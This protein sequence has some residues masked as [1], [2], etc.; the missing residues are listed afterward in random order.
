VTD[1]RAIPDAVQWHEGM[2]LSPQHFQQA[3]LRA[4]GLLSYLAFA[5]APYAWGVRRLQIDQAALVGG[6]FFV[7]DLEAVMP[8]GLLVLHP[9]DPRLPALELDLLALPPEAAA[10]GRLAVHLT[11][12][13]QSVLASRTGELQRYTALEGPEA[14]DANT[15]DNAIAIPRLLPVLGLQCTDGPQRPPSSRYVS[16]P[17]AVLQAAAQGFSPLP[18]EPPRQRV[19]RGQLLYQIAEGIAAD[20]RTKAKAWGELL[21]GALFRGRANIAGDSVATLRTI[22]RGLPRLEALLQTE[23]AHPLDVYLA[24]CDIAGD[25][26][27][28]GGQVRLPMFGKYVHADPRTAFESVRAFIREALDALRTPHR[29]VTLDHPAP[30][31][32]QLELLAEYQR[33]TLVIGAR[34]AP[35][36]DA[37]AV[38]AWFAAAMIGGAARIAAMRL[39]RVTGARRSVIASA[40][41]IDLVPPPNMLLFRIA[42]DPA[43]LS[44]GDTLQ[45]IRP[46]SEGP[47]EPDELQL[48]LP[49]NDAGADGGP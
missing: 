34:I 36:Q 31:R 40:P 7:T 49:A 21:R 4:Q 11:V 5:A 38:T 16:L 30:G 28:G 17:L 14:V 22:V 45:I 10:S 8:D 24:L 48:F 39:N 29:S 33:D 44:T 37:A 13:V 20:L 15:G 43:F 19:E 18:F 23:T 12:A 32:F 25:L 41:E 35:G 1:A 47:G 42:A 2:L 9:G 27:V 6:K 3:D 46:P 26:A